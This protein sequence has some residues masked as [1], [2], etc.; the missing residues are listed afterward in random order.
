M[1]KLSAILI[2]FLVSSFFFNYTTIGMAKT[3]KEPVEMKN[4]E[5]YPFYELWGYMAALIFLVLLISTII[6][7]RK[8]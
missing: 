7:K 2:I 1:L 5:I 4:N 6:H 8:L 3:Y